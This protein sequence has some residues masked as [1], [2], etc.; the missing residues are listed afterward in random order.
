MLY[1]PFN[2]AQRRAQLRKTWALAVACILL[3]ALAFKV[4]P[5]FLEPALTNILRRPLW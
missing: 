5:Y 3:F 2:E 4:I 1:E